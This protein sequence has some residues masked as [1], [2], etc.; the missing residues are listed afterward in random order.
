MQTLRS[1]PPG[2]EVDDSFDEAAYLSRTA[3]NSRLLGGV[4][5]CSGGCGIAHYCSCI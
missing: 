3:T 1:Y 5:W 4:T 2:E